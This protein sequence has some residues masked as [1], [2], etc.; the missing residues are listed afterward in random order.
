MF[1]DWGLL[2]DN[3]YGGGDDDDDDGDD[4]DGLWR[5]VTFYFWAQFFEFYILIVLTTT[6]W[7][8]ICFGN[9]CSLQDCW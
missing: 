3:E 4:D 5:D 6:A 1:V 9:V 8:S 2:I 7:H